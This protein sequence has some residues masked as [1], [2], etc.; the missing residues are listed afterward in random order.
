MSVE[1]RTPNWSDVSARSHAV[2]VT[3]ALADRL[4]PGEDP[5]GRGIGSNGPDATEWYRVVG[6]LPELRAEA[7]DV[8][9]TEAVFYAA[10]GLRAGVRSGELNDLSVFVRTAGADPFRVLPAIREVIREMDAQ[11]PI[12]RPRALTEV[13]N[14]SMSRTSFI[15]TLL[16]VAAT[17]ALTLSAVGTYGVISYLVTQRRTEMGVRLALGAT[18]AQVVRLVV[19]QSAKLALLGVGIGVVAAL[20]GTRLMASL[21]Y[22]VAASDAAVLLSGTALLL[23]VVLLASWVPARRASEVDPGEAMREH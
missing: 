12:V 11:V 7:L 16:A 6:V 5:I 1:G 15:L 9:P 14:R 8:P 3:R 10:T 4:W 13:V 18:A 22:G 20:A 23:T 19:S 21:L 17:I 2:V